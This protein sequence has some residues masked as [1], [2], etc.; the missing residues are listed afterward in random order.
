M[1]ICSSRSSNPRVV[2]YP[3]SRQKY[4]KICWAKKPDL[5]VGFGEVGD[6]PTE[7]LNPPP[8]DPIYVGDFEVA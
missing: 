7:P 4:S 6:S 1:G 8:D 2:R 5:F 3:P